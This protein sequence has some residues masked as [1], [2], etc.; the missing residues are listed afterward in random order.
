MRNLL[1]LL[2]IILCLNACTKDSN[3][4]KAQS[5][6]TIT[7]DALS[8]RWL[9]QTSTTK[10]YTNGVLTDSTSFTNNTTNVGFGNPVLAINFNDNLSGTYLQPGIDGSPFTYVISGNQMTYNYGSNVNLPT[11]FTIKSF[12]K[13][14]LELIDGTAAANGKVHDNIYIKQ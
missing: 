2:C 8:G 4:L 14:Q 11:T 13:T 7:P 3:N 6:L 9:L 1:I 10:S 5:N 12:T